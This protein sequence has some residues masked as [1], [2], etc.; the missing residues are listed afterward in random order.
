MA[1]LPRLVIPDQLHHIIARGNNDQPVFR[2][3][4]DYQAFLHW[5]RAAALQAGVALHA[6]VLLP[7]RLQLLATPPN[8]LALG[9]MMQAVGRAYVRYFNLRHQRTGQFHRPESGDLG[10]GRR[11]EAERQ[12]LRAFWH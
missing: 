11:S 9:K 3:E 1:R 7:N 12:H 5:L 8:E 4:A 2:E 6:Y 10:P